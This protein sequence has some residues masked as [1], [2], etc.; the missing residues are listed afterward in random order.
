[1]DWIFVYLFGFAGVRVVGFLGGIRT[2]LIGRW[3]VGI[4]LFVVILVV[5]LSPLL[6]GCPL[7][8]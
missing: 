6:L 7:L 5:D 3:V 1:M 8:C 2:V 4:A